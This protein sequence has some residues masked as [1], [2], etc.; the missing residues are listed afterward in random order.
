[1][2]NFSLIDLAIPLRLAPRV[3]QPSPDCLVTVVDTQR[4][5]NCSVIKSRMS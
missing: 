1:M 4:N 2:V 5:D 3:N